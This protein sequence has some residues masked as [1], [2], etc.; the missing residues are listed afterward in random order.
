MEWERDSVTG[1]GRCRCKACPRIMHP[2]YL[3]FG[4]LWAGV[5]CL[6]VERFKVDGEGGLRIVEK[7]GRR[8]VK[9]LEVGRPGP[10]HR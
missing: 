7:G 8:S 10:E 2:H 6:E 1:C 3:R 9:V 5:R 4:K